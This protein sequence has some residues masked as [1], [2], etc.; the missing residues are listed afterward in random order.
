VDSQEIENEGFFLFFFWREMSRDILFVGY[1]RFCKEF[2]HDEVKSLLRTL[3]SIGAIPKVVGYEVEASLKQAFMTVWVESVDGKRLLLETRC[4]RDHLVWLIAEV[5]RM[6]ERVVEAA[7]GVWRVRASDIKVVCTGPPRVVFCSANLNTW[8]PGRSVD[9]CMWKFC[10]ELLRLE[11][12]ECLKELGLGE[13]YEKIK[14]EVPKA[15]EIYR[16]R[17]GNKIED[18]YCVPGSRRS[19]IMCECKKHRKFLLEESRSVVKL[20]GR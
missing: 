10:K 9:E 18:W 12:P 16:E 6:V 4:V 13:L 19:A 2:S 11:V 14:G 5:R 8:K 15:C 17:T 20:S 3:E 1:G 7:G